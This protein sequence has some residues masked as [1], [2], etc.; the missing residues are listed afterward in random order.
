M[1]RNGPVLTRSLSYRTLTC[2]GSCHRITLAGKGNEA[3]GRGAGDLVL[4]VRQALHARFERRGDDLLATAQV[5]C[6]LP[7]GDL[8]ASIICSGLAWCRNYSLIKHFVRGMARMCHCSDAHVI[9]FMSRG[10]LCTQRKINAV[11][12]LILYAGQSTRDRQERSQ[13]LTRHPAV[14]VPLLQALAGGPVPL[15]ALDG[16]PL[17]VSLGDTAF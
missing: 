1:L 4:V 9:M 2:S 10:C 6:C 15:Q 14:Q 3:P 16:R 12:C 7:S 13:Q 8:S 5:R 11:L 17:Q